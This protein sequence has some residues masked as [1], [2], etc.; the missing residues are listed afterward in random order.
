MLRIIIFFSL[1]LLPFISGCV[2]I[3][4]AGGAL[5]AHAVQKG[6]EDYDN[7]IVNMGYRYKAYYT[8]M[9]ESNEEREKKGEP[10]LDILSFESW[11]EKEVKTDKER[12]AVERYKR[13]HANNP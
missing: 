4:I 10:A 13:I 1:S 9:K 2:L 3:P 5:V 8:E 12:K 7:I 6:N 11:I